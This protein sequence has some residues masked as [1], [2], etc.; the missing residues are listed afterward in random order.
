MH[1]VSTYVHLDTINA[2]GTYVRSLIADFCHIFRQ[3]LCDE[4]AVTRADY[5]HLPHKYPQSLCRYMHTSSEKVYMFNVPHHMCVPVSVCESIQVCV[6]AFNHA[7]I[8][9]SV[10]RC[11]WC[12]L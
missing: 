6:G 4:S 7:C 9:A 1:T 5:P 2:Q 3:S 12:M 8:C 10:C 11:A